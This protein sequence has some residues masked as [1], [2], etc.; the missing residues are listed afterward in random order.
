MN[1]LQNTVKLIE[2]KD[3]RLLSGRGGAVVKGAQLI[4]RVSW[5]PCVTVMSLKVKGKESTNHR[6]PSPR[7]TMKKDTAVA[8][9]GAV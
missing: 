8:T 2:H 7:W 6:L 1:H 4:S 5:T 3:Q 9:P